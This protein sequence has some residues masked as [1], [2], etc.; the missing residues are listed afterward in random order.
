MALNAVQK[1]NTT[2]NAETKIINGSECRAETTALD[3][4]LKL[5]SMSVR[6]KKMTLSVVNEKTW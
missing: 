3:A 1:Q 2:L 6:L 4:K 5:V